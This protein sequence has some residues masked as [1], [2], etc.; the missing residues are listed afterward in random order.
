M[1]D[2]GKG[3][4]S[5]GKGLKRWV[6]RGVIAVVALIL[7]V[8]TLVFVTSEMALSK[9][10]AVEPVPLAVKPSA[11]MV[12]RG[13][14]LA[15]YRGCR[16]CH[17][18]NLAGR[19]V[20]DDLPVMR[21]AG[22][23]ITPSSR[24]KDYSDVDLARV[25]R[26]GLQP[27]G[28]PVRFM[29]SY[30]YTKLSHGDLAAMIAYVRSVPGVDEVG[31]TFELGPVGRA[32]YLAGELPL[33]PAETIDHKLKPVNPERAPTVEYGEYL[34]TACSGCHGPEFVGGKIPGVPPDWPIAPNLTAH[35]S[36]LKT[37]SFEDFKKALRKGKRPDGTDIQEQ[38]MPWKLAGQSPDDDLLALW[39]YLRSVDPKP[40]G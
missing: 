35:E 9:V 6:F 1:S 19:V 2:T 30:E 20:A 17:G 18:E 10:Y 16:D 3:E 27:D 11:S 8:V 15:T 22:P 7:G 28:T 38:Y 32:L 36:G 25:I 29:P 4:K 14:E 24:I 21:L 37:W 40:R 5:G 31:P 26:H 23:N 12:E 34:A 39:K 33:I 13:K